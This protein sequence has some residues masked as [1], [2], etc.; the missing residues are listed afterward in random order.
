[1]ARAV[2]IDLGTTNSVVSVLEGG[3]PTVIANAEGFRTTPSVV[4]FTKDGETLVGETAKRQAVTNVDRTIASVKR[5]MGTDWTTEIDGKKY[6]PQEIS[7]RIL[8]KLKRDAEQYLGEPVTDA[9]ITV[10]AY[11]N[12]SE[13][14]ATKDAGE[15]A[16]L[17]VLR[18]IN[19]PTA[20]ALAYGL[21]KGKQD[22]LILVFDLG[23]GTFDVSLLE[24]GKDDDFSTIQVRST[25]GDNRL[26]GDDWDQ[27]V[28]DYL[29]KRFKDSTGVDVSSDKIAK[30]RLKEA[31]EQAKKELS[32]SMSTSIQLPYL[33][34]TENGPANLDESLTRA[35]FEELTND[36]LERTKKPFHDVIKEAGVSVN[37]IAHVVL[38]GGSTRTPA[39][40][41]LVKNMLGGKEPN[42]GVNPDEVVAVGAAL[43]AGVLKGE[44][45]DVLLI[46]VTPLSL[47]IE[48][49]GGIMTKLIER[50]TAIPTKRSETFTTAD[51]N[52]PSVAIQVFQGER[53]FTRDNKNLGTFEL[54][55]IAPA[56]RGVPQVE[57]TFDIDAN[58]IVQV[59]AKDKGTGK[60]QSIT[61][62]GGSALSKEDIE[63]MVRE[64]EENAAE[65]KRRREAAEVRNTAEQFVYSTEKLIKENDEKL[66]DGVKTDVQADIDALKS[67]LAG[68]DDAAVKTAL[69]KLNESQQKIGE[70]IYAQSQAEQPAEGA[71]TETPESSDEDIVDAEVVDD[72]PTENK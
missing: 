67:A 57:V 13:R 25:A 48:T 21:D 70:E 6:T 27:R 2:G 11:F 32:S 29:I 7:A 8:A 35:K 59:H 9:V 71:P 72:E 40:Q 51:D 55:G 10:P 17:N 47:G 43:Q 64:G 60:E 24:V 58:G 23:G 46:D 54:Q 31:A 63:R 33:S 12:D 15:I 4:A 20:A 19:E 50:N 38:V 14:Q 1:M 16:G 3:E 45:K 22:E 68:D 28:V 34:L 49:K 37:D 69:D 44:R 61:I 56:P 30:Q 5:H 62:T 65:D 36:L 66:S 26:G 52:Q 39:V 41:E 18:I 53:E 42:K